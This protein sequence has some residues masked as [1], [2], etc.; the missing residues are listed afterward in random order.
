MNA[1]GGIQT[2]M[3]NA[4]TMRNTTET[5]REYARKGRH[6]VWYAHT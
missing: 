1:A 4:K 6:R 2:A 5:V 3:L